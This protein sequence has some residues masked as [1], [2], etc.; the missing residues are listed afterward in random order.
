MRVFPN[1]VPQ[2][3]S[4]FSFSSWAICMFIVTPNFTLFCPRWEWLVHLSFKV[5]KEQPPLSHH[6][7][8][9]DLGLHSIRASALSQ[10]FVE[11]RFILLPQ[12]Q[13]PTPGMQVS[14]LW[15]PL[16]READ[17]VQ[18]KCHKAVL[19]FIN[20]IFLD[21][22]FTNCLKCRLF[23]NF[24]TRLILTDFFFFMFL[25]KVGPLELPTV[26]FPSSP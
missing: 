22:V 4:V 9:R 13:V 1:T 14:T 17:W 25:W 10:T 23:S 5:F 2:N 24:L 15:P 20:N 19:L 12:N 6:S 26:P 16:G 8:L 11:S 21:L 7:T 3:N 18:A